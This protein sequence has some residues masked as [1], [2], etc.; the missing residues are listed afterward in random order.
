MPITD[1]SLPDD[2]LD[3]ILS[4]LQSDF[5]VL[6]A[7]SQS[8]PKF[9]RLVER[10][11]YAI[12]TL[13]D[14]DTIS[15]NGLGTRQFVSLL[16]D[17]PHIANYIRS[18][19]VEATCTH[20]E[21][22]QYL[23]DI[24]SVLR[25]CSLLNKITLNEM[26]FGWAALPEAFRLAFLD[27]LSL[28]SMKAVCIK[29]AFGFPLTALEPAKNIKQLTLHG[30]TPDDDFIPKH[31]THPLLEELSIQDCGGLTLEKIIIWVQTRNLRSLEFFGRPDDVTREIGK[32]QSLLFSCSNTLVN[33]TLDI[34]TGCESRTI[35]Y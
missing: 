28:S 17:N 10:H 31:S 23:E 12:V 22:T 6:K 13:Y 24:A 7:C 15:K 1:M 34:R 26:A 25:M 4:F 18:M 19:E 14:N 11:L 30:W 21:S 8:D 27:C 3:H 29:H 16:S 2:I 20:V 35:I 5:P 32:L 9:I 33:L